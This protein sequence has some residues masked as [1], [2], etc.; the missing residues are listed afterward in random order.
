MGKRW[1]FWAL[2][3]GLIL[4]FVVPAIADTGG[5]MGGGD[6]GGGGGGGGGGYSGGGGGDW[7]GGG[8]YDS[9]SG[10]S[11]GG[12]SGGGGSMNG[13]ELIFIII[14]FVI[15][16]VV[17]I[18][19][20]SRPV[21][22][23]YS[24]YTPS[25]DPAPTADVTVLRVAIDGRARKFVQKELTRIAGVADTTTKEGR[26]AMLR[27][28]T[29]LV[30][31]L[32]DA[33]VYGGA[34]NEPMRMIGSAKTVFDQHVDQARSKFEEETIRNF[35][36]Q[37]T[38]RAASE[39]TARSDEGEGLI[40]VQIIIA[41]KLELFTVRSIGNGDDLRAAL[42][43]A[44]QILPGNLIALEIVWQP[45]EENDRL[46]SMELEAKYPKP[47]II[48]IFGALVGKVFCDYCSGPFPAELV[49]CP[50]CGAPAPGRAKEAA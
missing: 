17:K 2:L 28:V 16:M 39:Y 24:S 9:S 46:S 26:A 3:I 40:L 35:Q 41:A 32:R 4:W 20:S 21:F 49:S 5:S 8:G 47:E 34:V 36:G 42:E 23:S 37:K 10:W 22:D 31:K 27:E 38:T 48:P 13:V 50:H 14:I 7:G 45:S 1:V 11:S 12:G 43:S 44:S 19:A 29:V 25:Y 6:W 18:M 30:R 33:W 15:F